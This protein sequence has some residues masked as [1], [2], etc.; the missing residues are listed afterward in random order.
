MNHTT[1]GITLFGSNFSE[2][3]ASSREELPVSNANF[4][5]ISNGFR[6][7]VHECWF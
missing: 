2:R 1:L 4:I 6:T 5:S 7:S 3:L